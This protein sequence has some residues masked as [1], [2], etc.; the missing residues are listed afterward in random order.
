MKLLREEKDQILRRFETREETDREPLSEAAGEVASYDNH[1][2]DL[3]TETAEREREQGVDE[4]F[5]EHLEDIDLALASM[6]DGTYGICETCREPIPYERLEII[7]STRYC[8]KHARAAE[9]KEAKARPP[10][11]EEELRYNDDSGAWAAVE[12]YG[13]S[14]SMSGR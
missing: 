4:V 8:V 5:R 3:A 7:P 2:A 14:S 13:N 11:D 6:A 12:A 1:P 10:E 9:A